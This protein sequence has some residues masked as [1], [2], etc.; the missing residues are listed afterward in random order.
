MKNC[1]LRAPVAALSLAVL[2]S[3]PSHAQTAASGNLPETV[4]TATRFNETLTSLPMGVSV[5]TA[6]QIRATGATTVNG[7]GML[8]HQAAYAFELWTGV[9]APVGAMRDAVLGHLQ[10]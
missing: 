1:I 8:L 9:A 10:Q 4:V 5:I 2:A 3:S 7:V 6:D